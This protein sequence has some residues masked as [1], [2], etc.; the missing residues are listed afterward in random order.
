MFETNFDDDDGHGDD[1]LPFFLQGR[2]KFSMLVRDTMNVLPTIGLQCPREGRF[3]LG[4]DMASHPK[5]EDAR[6]S[7]CISLQTG[8][9]SDIAA[10]AQRIDPVKYH[11]CVMRLSLN[12]FFG[13]DAEP[14]V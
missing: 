7:L 11:A 2:R 10:N 14:R 8:R 4:E 9:W 12:A 6:G 5:Q 1:E 3:Y 13:H